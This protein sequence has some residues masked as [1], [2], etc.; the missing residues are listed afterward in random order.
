M[1][2]GSIFDKLVGSN[3]A[4]YKV[5]AETVAGILSIIYEFLSEYYKEHEPLM[6]IK[7][8]LFLPLSTR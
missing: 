3:S 4:G 1:D 2:W 6:Q 5:S 7:K 8:V